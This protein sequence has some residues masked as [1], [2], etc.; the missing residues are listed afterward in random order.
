LATVEKRASKSEIVQLSTAVQGRRE[1]KDNWTR[2]GDT[3]YTRK[4]EI[5][6]KLERTE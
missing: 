5:A 4:K 3:T 1:G 2:V 6:R